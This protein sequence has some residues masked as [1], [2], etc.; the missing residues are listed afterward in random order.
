MTDEKR[1]QMALEA[2][3]VSLNTIA[4]TLETFLEMFKVAMEQSQG[5]D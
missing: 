5:D 3:A 1:K 2:I 4:N